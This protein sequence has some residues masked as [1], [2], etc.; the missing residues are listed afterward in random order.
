MMI[1]ISREKKND[2]FAYGFSVFLSEELACT[3]YLAAMVVAR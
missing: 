2:G 3:G 1:E